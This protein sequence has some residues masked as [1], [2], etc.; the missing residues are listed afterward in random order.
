MYALVNRSSP[1]HEISFDCKQQRADKTVFKMMSGS[2][3]NNQK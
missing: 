2:S 3:W 1:I